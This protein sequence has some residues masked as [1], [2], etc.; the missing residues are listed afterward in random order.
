MRGVWLILLAGLTV[1]APAHAGGPYPVVPPEIGVAPS[2]GPTWDT[3]RCAQGPV[4]SFYHDAYYGGEPPALYR[5]YAYRPFYRY[6]G[7]RRW[8]RKYLCVV[9]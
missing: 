1:T 7:Y 4:Y 3:Y 2:I 5:R 8:P 6:S 9:D